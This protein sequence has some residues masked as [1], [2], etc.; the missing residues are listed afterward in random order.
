M[1]KWRHQHS[2]EVDFPIRKVWDFFSNVSNWKT[3]RLIESYFQSEKTIVNGT[4]VIAKLK[5]KLTNVPMVFT[6]V[7][8]SREFKVLIKKYF[9]KQESHC[10]LQEVSPVKTKI[11]NHL[12]VT[13]I[14]APLCKSYLLK[15]VEQ[16]YIEFFEHMIK[17]LNHEVI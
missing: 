2:I 3:P 15:Y 1:F 12:V 16:Q 17:N 10:I 8:E 11:V 14:V 6:D 13:S 5:N 9:E 7:V 4:I